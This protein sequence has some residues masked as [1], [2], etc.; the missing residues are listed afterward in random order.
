MVDI[1]HNTSNGAENSFSHPTFA[2]DSR[3]SIYSK[4]YSGK[5]GNYARVNNLGWM[6]D[7]WFFGYSE[8]VG[9]QFTYWNNAY[10]IANTPLGKIISEDVD[11]LYTPLAGVVEITA[12]NSQVI[13]TVNLSSILNVGNTIS[14]QYS[15]T[16]TYTVTQVSS[17]SINISPIPNY[18][19]KTG[20][21][22]KKANSKNIYSVDLGWMY[23]G[24]PRGTR[25]SFFYL[26]STVQNLEPGS[27]T[28][29]KIGWIFC[30]P[31]FIMRLKVDSSRFDF[32]E[33]TQGGYVFSNSQV[34]E[35]GINYITLQVTFVHREWN[36]LDAWWLIMKNSNNDAFIAMYSLASHQPNQITFK[37]I[38]R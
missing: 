28:A 24:P 10:W 29:D 34:T 38:N 20:R 14:F 35:N 25:G 33:V 21:I 22:Y 6:Y 8:S 7:T 32:S 15:P 31:S 18:S 16:Q 37:K 9:L 17:N 19:D 4:Y 3:F 13:T 26:H 27:S 1:I 5:D 30:E 12:G 36:N 23:L 2:L 11:Q